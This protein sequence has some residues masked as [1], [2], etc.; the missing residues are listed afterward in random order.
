MN[1][2]MFSSILLKLGEG[3]KVKR[4]VWVEGTYINK[5]QSVCPINNKLPCLYIKYKSRKQKVEWLPT[6]FDLCAQDWEIAK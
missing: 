1:Y 2:A 4:K 6:Q 3:C 5:G